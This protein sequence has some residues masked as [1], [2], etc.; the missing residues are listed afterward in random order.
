MDCPY[1]M[2]QGIGYIECKRGYVRKTSLFSGNEN[3]D[4]H[5]RKHCNC[6]YTQCKTYKKLEADWGHVECSGSCAVSH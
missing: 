6:K 1:Y 5:I 4:K 2:D 3:R